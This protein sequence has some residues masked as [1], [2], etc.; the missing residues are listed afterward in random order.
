MS[1]DESEEFSSE[2]DI[3]MPSKNF[4][5]TLSAEEWQK[6][7]PKEVVYKLTKSHTSSRSYMVLPKG[8]W[9]PVL[10]E[11]FWI[12]TELPCNLAFK[13]A[14]VY[15]IGQVYVKVVG[16]CSACGSN[17]EGSVLHRPAENTK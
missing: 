3:D 8:N 5:F 6:I 13:R 10:A 1:S 12:H 16:R 15:P 7:Q 9:T 17:F 2:N 14:K 11:H 4:I